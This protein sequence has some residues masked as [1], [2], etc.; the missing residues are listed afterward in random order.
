[1]GPDSNQPLSDGLLVYRFLL[2]L[3]GPL[4]VGD[5]VGKSVVISLF[6]VQWLVGPD[7]YSD[8]QIGAYFTGATPTRASQELLGQGPVVELTGGTSTQKYSTLP[9]RRYRRYTTFFWAK[10]VNK[11]NTTISINHRRKVYFGC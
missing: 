2:A 3:Y 9:N 10:Q 4:D 11:R 1:M 7:S 6:G 5:I 8:G